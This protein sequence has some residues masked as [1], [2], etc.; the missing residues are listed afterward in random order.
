M[1]KSVR[2]VLERRYRRF[3]KERCSVS[4]RLVVVLGEA[5]MGAYA[6]F[7]TFARGCNRPEA[8]GHA[9]WL[10]TSLRH[11]ALGLIGKSQDVDSPRN[12]WRYRL[13]F[14]PVRK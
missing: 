8:A 7:L 2:L 14:V 3:A 10:L 13:F 1:G 6:Q 5:A 4:S 12:Q 11:S 9:R